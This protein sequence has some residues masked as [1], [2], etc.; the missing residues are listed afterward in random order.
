MRST[1]RKTYP[2]EKI[3]RGVDLFFPIR[4]THRT[5]T[6]THSEPQTS[7]A[8]TDDIGPK[9]RLR[10]NNQKAVGGRLGKRRAPP[11]DDTPLRHR[12][13]HQKWIGRNESTPRSPHVRTEVVRDFKLMET[14]NADKL[15]QQRRQQQRPQRQQQQ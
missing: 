3:P 4:G 2:G 13:Q 10:K 14:I 6:Q 7:R 15:K 11:G 12:F 9:Q 5:N 8:G 1:H